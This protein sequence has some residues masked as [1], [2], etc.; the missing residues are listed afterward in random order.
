MKI[1]ILVLLFALTSINLFSL[2]KKDT[3]NKEQQSQGTNIE[4]NIDKKTE[5]REN[6]IKIRGKISIFGSEPRTFAGIVDENGTE[7][8]IHPSSR[9]DQ[10]RKLQGHLIEFTVI[11]LDE[12]SGYGGMFLK[13]GT[14]TPVSWEIIR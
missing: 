2:G 6:Q 5:N 13:G 9:E 11:M 8:A 10:L 3:M 12:P 1:L 14:V 7:Y 4:T